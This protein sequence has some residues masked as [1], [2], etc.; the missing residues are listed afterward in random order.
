MPADI[1]TFADV[2]RDHHPLHL[3]ALSVMV[4]LSSSH[5]PSIALTCNL[6]L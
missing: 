1:A 5:P 4:P 3:K 2:T 6:L